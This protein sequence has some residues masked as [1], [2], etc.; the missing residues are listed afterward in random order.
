MH[1]GQ[2]LVAMTPVSVIP[3][4]Q[5]LVKCRLSTPH[6]NKGYLSAYIQMTCSDIW[7]FSPSSCFASWVSDLWWRRR[8]PSWQLA[9]PGCSSGSSCPWNAVWRTDGK[10]TTAHVTRLQHETALNKHAAKNGMQQTSLQEIAISRT[11]ACL[12][13]SWTFQY[14]SG[15]L[16]LVQQDSVKNTIS[17]LPSLHHGVHV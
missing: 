5:Y 15:P 6:N 3:W 8:K 7:V 1:L 12:R 16:L 17:V 2:F 4:T 13:S 10:V 14:L 9:Q 11:R